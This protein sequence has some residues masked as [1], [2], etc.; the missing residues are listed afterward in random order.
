MLKETVRN[1]QLFILLSTMII[2]SGCEDNDPKILIK[3]ELGDI[4]VELYQ[5]QAPITAY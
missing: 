4:V 3:T 5:K 1:S 2:L